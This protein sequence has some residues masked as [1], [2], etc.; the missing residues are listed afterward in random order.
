MPD[1]GGE[2]DM[3]NYDDKVWRMVMAVLLAFAFL[4][5]ILLAT[6]ILNYLVSVI[7]WPRLLVIWTFLGT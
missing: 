1:D 4:M 5:V 7:P 2:S 3:S 6:V